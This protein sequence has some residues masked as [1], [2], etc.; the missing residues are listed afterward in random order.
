MCTYEVAD[1]EPELGGKIGETK[2][3]FWCRLG[4]VRSD[5]TL[6]EYR[7]A[8]QSGFLALFDGELAVCS[9]WHIRC[10]LWGVDLIL[11]GR[12][13]LLELSRGHGRF[14]AD[15]WSG[16]VWWHRGPNEAGDVALKEEDNFQFF[17][18]VRAVR[19]CVFFSF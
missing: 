5:L 13:H 14:D 9:T 12:G 16:V 1:L 8:L 2:E 11:G 18:P 15:S 19:Q 6:L 17:N 4:H 10:G 7:L 3:C